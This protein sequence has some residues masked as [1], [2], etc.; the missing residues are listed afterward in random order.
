MARSLKVENLLPQKV[1]SIIN[2]LQQSTEV[3]Q[4]GTPSC[5]RPQPTTDN[6]VREGRSNWLVAPPTLMG[7]TPWAPH[8][9]INHCSLSR[10]STLQIDPVTFSM[11][12]NHLP[13]ALS[14]YS[15]PLRGHQG[16]L[17]SHEGR[18]SLFWVNWFQVRNNMC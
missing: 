3:G 1:R 13:Y 15:G 11:R 4:W 17:L 8:D 14:G 7:N 16:K 18:C 10:E 9:S 2:Y 12:G 6:G 5:S